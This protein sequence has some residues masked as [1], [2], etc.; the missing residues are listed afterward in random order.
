[1]LKNYFKIALRNLLRKKMYAVI[2]IFGL[3]VAIACCI[4]AYLN[5]DYSYSFD[6]FHKNADNIFRVESIRVINGQ[7]QRWG[8]APLPLGPALAQDFSSV[9]RAVRFADERA[10]LRYQDQVFNENIHYADPG[11]FEMFTFSMKYGSADVLNDKTRLVL[12]EEYAHKYFGDDNPIGKPITLRYPNGQKLDF[13]VG[14]VTRKTPR[15]S[16]LDF[17]I[18]ASGEILVDVGI[19]EPNNWAHWN[20]ATF[21]QVQNPADIATLHAQM[22]KYIQAQNSA[23]HQLPVAGFYFEPLRKIALTSRDLR[24]NGL[25]NGV[26]P[27]AI[28]GPSIIGVLLL[29]MACGNYMN[30]SIAFSA[31]R[32]KEIGVRKVLGASVGHITHLINREFLILLVLA[33]VSA[34]AAGYFAIEALLGSIYAYHIHPTVLAFVIAGVSVFFVA[35]FTVGSQVYRVATANPVNALRYE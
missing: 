4:V 19:D 3:S 25:S 15:N 1:M 12:S 28:A 33:S 14:A 24:A 27:S 35:I 23:D 18:L 32:L 26:P 20:T 29:L 2:N 34:Y 5:Y 6:A 7:E 22:R 10:V 13:R 8:I 9:V 17:D 30:T 21:V 16:S 31:N 11:F